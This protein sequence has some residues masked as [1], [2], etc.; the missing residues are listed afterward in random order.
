MKNLLVRT[1]FYWSWVGGTVLTVRTEY[2]Q[3]QA[4]L[5]LTLNI[6]NQDKCSKYSR[7]SKFLFPA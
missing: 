7:A 4:A 3:Y 5:F 2:Y 6:L 1:K